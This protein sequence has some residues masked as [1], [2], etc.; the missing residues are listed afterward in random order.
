MTV[1]FNLWYA[2]SFLVARSKFISY[3]VKLQFSQIVNVIFSNVRIVFIKTMVEC[4]T[5]LSCKPPRSAC[6]EETMAT[7]NNQELVGRICF[8][9]SGPTYLLIN[10]FDSR[11][12]HAS[13]SSAT[14]S[15][16]W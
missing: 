7:I 4:F 1:V 11:F 13:A 16:C 14:E 3:Q 6:G 12:Y 5:Q 2:K 8:E 15:R 9:I 10:F